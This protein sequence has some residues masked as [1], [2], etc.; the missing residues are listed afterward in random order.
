MTTYEFGYNR[1]ELKV[2]GPAISAMRRDMHLS[3]AELAVK[4][5]LSRSAIARYESEPGK[6]ITG[7]AWRQLCKAL[8]LK[9]QRDMER[10]LIDDGPAVDMGDGTREPISLYEQYLAELAAER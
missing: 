6:G 5:K 8:G 9:S 4:A 2:N 1:R 10:I 7:R 3:Q